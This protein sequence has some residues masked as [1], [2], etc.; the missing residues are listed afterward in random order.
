M[1]EFIMEYLINL[2]SF[3]LFLNSQIFV[4]VFES[5]TFYM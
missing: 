4:F 5:V 1:I 2:V 3:N